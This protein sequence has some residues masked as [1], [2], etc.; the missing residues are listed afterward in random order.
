[1]EITSVI[2]SILA[3]FGSLITYIVHDRKIKSQE[4]KINNYMIDKLKREEAEDKK[5]LISGEI[6]KKEA[7]KHVLKVCN[8]GKAPANNINIQGL[9]IK[10]IGIIDK[11]RLHYELFNPQDY[12][13]IP[14]FLTIGVPSNIKLT[15]I[16][17]DLYQKGNSL[18]Q[19]LS[20]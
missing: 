7:N 9:D 4:F 16:W 20:L 17:E 10:G 18:T 6:I 13:E 19:I 12:F 11:E 1:M 14:F 3:L 5:A 8:N 15:Y 2:I